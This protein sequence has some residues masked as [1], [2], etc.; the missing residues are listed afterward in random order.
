MVKVDTISRGFCKS[1]RVFMRQIS[2]IAAIAVLA[3][4]GAHAQ[5]RVEVA[6]G[7][8]SFEVPTTWRTEDGA[9]ID[10]LIQPQS[11]DDSFYGECEVRAIKM[12]RLGRDQAAANTQ[13]GLMPPSLGIENGASLLERTYTEQQGVQIL[14]RSYTHEGWLFSTRSLGIVEGEMLYPVNALCMAQVG[15]DELTGEIDAFL[16]SLQISPNS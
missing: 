13:I 6:G 14:S 16:R 15:D 3:T 8:V 2:S 10:L 1:E 11:A 5:Q 12:P 4:T 7:L 9:G